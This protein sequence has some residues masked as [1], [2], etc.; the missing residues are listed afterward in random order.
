MKYRILSLPIL[1]AT[2]VSPSS[3]AQNYVVYGTKI[4]S[5]IQSKSAGSTAH[6]IASEKG[7]YNNSE[8]PWCGNRAYIDIDDSALISAALA[9][10]TSNQLVHFIYN[11]AAPEKVANGHMISRCQVISIF[12]TP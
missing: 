8:H 7:I 11:D 5:Y 6:L 12:S 2:L 9:A 3:F 1:M 10:S 4:H